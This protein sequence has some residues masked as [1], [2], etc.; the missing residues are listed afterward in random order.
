MFE[1]LI[2]W[3]VGTLFLFGAYAFDTLMGGDKW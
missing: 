3:S 1:I 2:S